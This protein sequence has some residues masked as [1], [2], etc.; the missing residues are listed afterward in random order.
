MQNVYGHGRPTRI[1]FFNESAKIEQYVETPPVVQS[2]N[3]C[4]FKVRLYVRVFRC[5]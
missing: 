3:L 4:V 5:P 1:A 2:I